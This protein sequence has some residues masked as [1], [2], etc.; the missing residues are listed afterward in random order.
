VWCV[1]DHQSGEPGRVAYPAESA[2]GP[3]RWARRETDLFA[4]G[5]VP[6][7]LPASLAGVRTR[8]A[9]ATGSSPAERQIAAHRAVLEGRLGL[10]SPAPTVLA[11]RKH[12]TDAFGGV[13][14]AMARD[15]IACVRA[16]NDAAAANPDAGVRPLALDEQD[17]ENTE[18]P[19]WAVSDRGTLVG[20]RAGDLGNGAGGDAGRTARDRIRPRA[21]LFTGLLRALACDLFIHGTGG[22]AYDRVTEVWLRDWLGWTLAPVGVATATLTLDLGVPDVT[23]ADLRAARWRAHHARH[24]PGALGDAPA[25]RLAADEKRAL[26]GRIRESDAP[27]RAGLFAAMH[28]LLSRVRAE[29]GGALAALDARAEEVAA[30]LADRAIAGDRTW[31]WMLHS[32]RDLAGLRRAIDDAVRGG[33]S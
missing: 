11:T 32:D 5:G 21:L 6:D 9:A 4:E 19:L 12:A 16:Y 29:H 22:G 13:L 18:L 8:L 24:N 3:G 25:L 7:D 10:S 1:P 27:D 2:G 26:V 20:V 23:R 28:A 17:P 14:D 30:A 33:R 15:P 31:A